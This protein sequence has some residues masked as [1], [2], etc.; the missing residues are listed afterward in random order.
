MEEL[1]EE[2]KEQLME[3]AEKELRLTAEERLAEERPLTLLLLEKELLEVRAVETPLLEAQLQPRGAGALLGQVR[4]AELRRGKRRSRSRS[5]CGASTAPGRRRS[6][7]RLRGAMTA[8]SPRLHAATAPS[9]STT[10]TKV[11]RLHGSDVRRP[12]PKAHPA[13]KRSPARG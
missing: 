4:N 5:W 13:L 6:G 3:E 1:M 7:A 12:R 9:C 11:R 8:P 10:Q 2:L